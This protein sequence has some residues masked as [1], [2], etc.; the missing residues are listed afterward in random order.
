MGCVFLL[1]KYRPAL[2]EDEYYAEHQRRQEELTRQA[3]E[4][5]HSAGLSLQDLARGR[6]LDELPEEAR[7]NIKTLVDDLKD[8]TAEARGEQS[9]NNEIDPDT[10]L[11]LA[12]GLMAEKKWIAAGRKFEE[13]AQV[14]PG[15]WEANYSRGVAFANARGGTETD[16]AAVRA[17]MMQLRSRP[18]LE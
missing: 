5:L 1:T 7:Q 6:T 2:Q 8:T 16:L 15:D 18:A 11:V 17:S 12:Q 13:Y 14:R 10:V 4:Q 9:M 3:E